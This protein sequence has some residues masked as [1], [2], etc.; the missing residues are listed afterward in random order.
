MTRRAVIT[1]MGIVSC[2]GNDVE[3]VAG[4]LYEGRSGISLHQEQIDV[5]MRSHVA[6]APSLDIAE[7]IDRTKTSLGAVD[8]PCTGVFEMKDGKIR[9]WR[10]YFD[11]NTFM[12]A[13]QS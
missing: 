11:L 6:G 7:R 12:G 2:L 10:D 5:G 13:M 4:S 9:V 1:G 8:L 3:T